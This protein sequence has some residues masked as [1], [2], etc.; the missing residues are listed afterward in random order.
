MRRAAEE[1]NPLEVVV[2]VAQSHSEAAGAVEMRSGVEAGAGCRRAAAI[3]RAESQA[4]ERK[5]AL[6]S[7]RR[8]QY[9]GG[10]SRHSADKSRYPLHVTL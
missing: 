2:A 10:W 3:P 1:D 5:G 8:T 9:S 6:R 7:C 4:V